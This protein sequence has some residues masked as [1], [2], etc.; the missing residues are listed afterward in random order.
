MGSTSNQP[1]TDQPVN[2]K[3]GDVDKEVLVDPYDTNKKLCL[4]TE[5]D[6]K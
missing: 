2:D 3:K 4:S 6:A 1:I 5:L